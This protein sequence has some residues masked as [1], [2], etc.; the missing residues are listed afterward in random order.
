M[1]KSV[2]ILTAFLPM[3]FPAVAQ[4]MPEPPE[5]PIWIAAIWGDVELIEQHIAAGTDIDAR[6]DDAKGHTPLYAATKKGK[7]EVVRILL[8]A[9]ADPNKAAT[10][11][12]FS[13][14]THGNPTPLHFAAYISNR[15]IVSLL[16][17]TGADPTL[18]DS[19]GKTPVDLLK[20]RAHRTF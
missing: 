12:Y 8:D 5:T 1:N 9:G 7:T 15:V 16:M 13:S 6:R 4:E 14:K 10:S 3:A 20:K 17:Q 11:D 2:L 18:E 19:N